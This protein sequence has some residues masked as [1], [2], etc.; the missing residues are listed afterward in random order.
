MTDGVASPIARPRWRAWVRPISIGVVFG[1]GMVVLTI[2][3]WPPPARSET[4]S[5]A[6]TPS[7]ASPSYAI[8]DSGTLRSAVGA[9]YKG[10][11]FSQTTLDIPLRRV[12]DG[13]SLTPR[14]AATL[15]GPDGGT[16]TCSSGMPRWSMDDEV[17]ETLDCDRFVEFDDLSG[18]TNIDVAVE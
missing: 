18:I 1:I 16:V 17:T 14:L 15:S 3:L 13:G 12:T 2:A 6:I 8:G 11:A 7:G 5:V 9:D 10:R 4:V